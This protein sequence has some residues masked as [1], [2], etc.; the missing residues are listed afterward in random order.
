[1]ACRSAFLAN[2]VS[3]SF[4]MLIPDAASKYLLDVRTWPGCAYR[5]L[6]A[7]ERRGKRPIIDGSLRF[8]STSLIREKTTYMGSC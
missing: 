4:W 5:L 1:V 2:A 6:A 3:T 8:I 7:V